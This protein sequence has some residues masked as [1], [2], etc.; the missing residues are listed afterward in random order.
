MKSLKEVTGNGTKKTDIE[1]EKDMD[2]KD[3]NICVALVSHSHVQCVMSQTVG[4]ATSF[5]ACSEWETELCVDKNDA[6]EPDKAR[7][8]E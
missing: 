5:F 6:A 1:L 4:S 7:R 3:T 2:R 8:W